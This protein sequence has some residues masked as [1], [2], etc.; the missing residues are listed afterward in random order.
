MRVAVYAINKDHAENLERWA[1]CAREADHII[2]ADTGSTD[3]SII[4]GLRAG[5]AM[6]SITIDP[7]RY[8]H[9][10]NAALDLVPDDVDYCIALDTDEFLQ[11]GWREHLQEAFDAG[12]T[13]PRYRYIWSWDE[14]GRPGLEFAAEKIH[15][16]HGYRWRHAAHETLF[17]EVEERQGWCG[18]EIHHH[19]KPKPYRAHELPLL[20]IAVKESPDDDRMAHYY[21]RT[22]LFAGREDEALVEF[23]RHLELPSARWADERAQSMRYIFRI[24]EDVRWLHKAYWQ[25]PHRREAAVDAAQFHHDLGE[26]DE[27]LLWAKRALKIKDRDLLYLTEPQ[28]WGSLPHDL[29]AVAAYNLELYREADYHGMEA[30]KLSPYDERLRANVGFYRGKVAA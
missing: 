4:V 21:A 25:A 11:P 24:T 3:D 5:I 7:W 20:E 10:R 15:P 2:M 6:H 19:Q 18:L 29:A 23:L 13:R 1:E 8:D 28:A 27:C 12:I 9:A 17:T 14:R 22:L 26:W 30:L 16:R